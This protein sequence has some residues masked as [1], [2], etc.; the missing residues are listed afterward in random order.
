ME[1]DELQSAMKRQL[2]LLSGVV[3]RNSVSTP[4]AKSQRV[5]KPKARS[6]AWSRY[7][8]IESCSNAKELECIRMA[9]NARHGPNCEWIASEKVHGANF[10]FETDGQ[11]VEYASR[12]GKLGGDAPFFNAR[13][14]MPKYHPFV[15][16]AFHIA[17]GHS[18][19]LQS[20]L[21]YGEY[22]GGYYPGHKAKPGLKKIQGGVAYSPDHHFYAF[23]VCLDGQE[24]MNF[25][26]ARNLLLAAG[27]PLVAAPL[28]RGNLDELLAIDVETFETTLPWQLGFPPLDRFRIAEGIVIR[29]AQ[30]VCFG[31]HRAILKKKAQAFWEATNQPNM[32]MKTAQFQAKGAF[33]GYEHLLEEVRGMCNENRLRAVISK[34]PSLL[35]DAQ[36][37][38]LA[39]LLAK[40]I[41]EDL[42]KQHDGEL[43]A[44]AKEVAALKKSLQFVTRSFVQDTVAR[45]REDIG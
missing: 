9:A 3:N 32:A 19:A 28:W 25:D 11:T 24:Y 44:M 12:T 8:S 21:I 16:Q 15:L 6:S 33:V 5:E 27:F 14:T 29:P 41:W 17:R 18:S 22:F 30:D 2:R 23:D 13:D 20:L 1:L 4:E 10:C 39:G 45:I 35:A 42:Q 7:S 38:K 26:D 34:D 43:T 40:D 36:A 31:S 37:F